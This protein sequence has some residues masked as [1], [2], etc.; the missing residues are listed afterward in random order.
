MRLLSAAAKGNVEGDDGLG[1]IVHV[2]GLTELCAKQAFLG[3]EHFEVA[4]LTI[5]HQLVG[6][7]IG[8]VEHF[9]LTMIVAVL[10]TGRLT[11]GY[12]LVHL[13][14]GINDRLH[15]FLL[16]VFL[17]QLVDFQV[18]LQLAACEYGLCELTDGAEQQLAWIDD[19]ATG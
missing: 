16:Q 1:T 10:L 4:G 5:V 18:G 3:G 6:T 13:V 14:A 15:I 11:V 8:I 2:R 12:C 9:H 19:H 17:C 7:G